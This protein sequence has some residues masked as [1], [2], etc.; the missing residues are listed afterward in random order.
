M[1]ER[2]GQDTY[3][4]FSCCDP[5]AVLVLV[6]GFGGHTN[7]RCKL[8]ISGGVTRD[9]VTRDA[10]GATPPKDMTSRA[11]AQ[12]RAN[13]PKVRCPPLASRPSAINF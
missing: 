5:P 2:R 4:R 8:L 11:Q 6:V 10:I 7:W 3:G 1:R 12:K 9:R 13:L